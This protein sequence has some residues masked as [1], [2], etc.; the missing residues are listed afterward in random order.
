[1]HQIAKVQKQ[2]AI[3]LKNKI[4]IFNDKTTNIGLLSELTCCKKTRWL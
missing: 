2:V 3:I 1:L 4:I